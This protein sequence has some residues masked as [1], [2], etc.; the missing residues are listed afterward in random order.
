[1]VIIINCCNEWG[2]YPRYDLACSS[3]RQLAEPGG[4]GELLTLGLR[5]LLKLGCRWFGSKPT[6]IFGASRMP[7]D[8]FAAKLHPELPSEPS[9]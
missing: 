2:Q 1:M 8:D 9:L 7:T 3:P 6:D 5:F 4:S